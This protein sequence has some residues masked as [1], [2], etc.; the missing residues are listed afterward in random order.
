MVHTGHT[1][2]TIGCRSSS[3]FLSE[4][5]LAG[6]F[7]KPLSLLFFCIQPSLIPTLYS[8]SYLSLLGCKSVTSRVLSCHPASQR[9]SQCWIHQLQ[10]LSQARCLHLLLPLPAGPGQAEVLLLLLHSRLL[11]M[12]EPGKVG[13][14]V[15]VKTKPLQT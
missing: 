8:S 13:A 14:V 3:L 5:K 12:R 6:W 1:S 11:K 10:R 7:W 15:W 4:E 2:G 9:A